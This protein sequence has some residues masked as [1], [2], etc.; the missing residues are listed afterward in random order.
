MLRQHNTVTAI[1]TLS[2]QCVLKLGIALPNK[3]Y[4]EKGDYN[5]CKHLEKSNKTL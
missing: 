5:C 2:S 4:Y 3:V 1:I